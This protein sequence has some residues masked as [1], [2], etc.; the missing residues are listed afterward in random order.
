MLKAK[1]RAMVKQHKTLVIAW[2]LSAFT[3]CDACRKLPELPQAHFQL[4]GEVKPSLLYLKNHEQSKLLINITPQNE[5]AEHI[6]YTL[7]EWSLPAGLRGNVLDEKG[8]TLSPGSKLSKGAHQFFYE[9]LNLGEHTLTLA[10]TDQYGDFPKELKL[11]PITVEE[12]AKLPFKAKLQAEERSIYQHQA[13]ELI[14][15]LAAD[16]EEASSA[17]YTV[18]DITAPSGTLV[19]VSSGEPLTIGSP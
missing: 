14:L 19:L 5:L 4:S 15:E 7:V 10:I 18:R 11:P 16:L 9:P 13:A 12:Q 17:A 1:R 2:L 3:A 8:K 6:H